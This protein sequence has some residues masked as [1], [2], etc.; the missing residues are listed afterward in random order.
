MA[1]L[2]EE[3]AKLGE[4]KLEEYKAIAIFVGVLFMWA[5][6]GTFHDIS[7]TA[8]AFIG[9]VIALMPGGIGVVK[10]NDVDV[11][12]HLMLFSAGA[13]VLGAGLDTT[14]LPG[15]MINT[16]FSHWGL[17]AE[18]PFWILFA[19]LTGAMMFSALIFQSKTMR[20]LIFVP[21]AI[22]VAQ[23]YGLPLMS[24]AVPVALLIEHV[25]V[26]PFNSKPAVLL[27][28]TNHYSWSD[29]FKFGFT[30]MVIAWL[31]MFLWGETV[32]KWMG[33]LPNGV[34]Y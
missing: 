30:M 1:R 28:G 17:C 10:W 9:A 8:V 21:I 15:T 22:G 20:C 29:T 16:L 33:Y 3:L 23:N 7:E 5:T 27:Y 13:Y 11:P 26:L 4:M 19:I 31:L 25:Y 6:R 24:L 14:N 34:F 2:R 18:T 12:W 32:L